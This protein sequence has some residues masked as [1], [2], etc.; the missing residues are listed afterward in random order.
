MALEGLMGGIKPGCC[1]DGSSKADEALREESV[2]ALE[3]LLEVLR[4]DLSAG[5]GAPSPGML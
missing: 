2:V 1:V 5:L 4:I 3:G